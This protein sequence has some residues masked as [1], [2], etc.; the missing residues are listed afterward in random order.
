MKVKKLMDILGL[1][2]KYRDMLM[3]YVNQMATQVDSNV[4]KVLLDR[5]EKMAE[6]S[7]PKIL[8]G[9]QEVYENTFTDKEIEQ[10]IEWYESDVGKKV[11]ERYLDVLRGCEDAAKKGYEY[12]LEQMGISQGQVSTYMPQK[13]YKDLN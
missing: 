8:E 13:S 6:L 11:N 1:E 3:K 9:I 2:D 12:A 5:G 4:A 7:V 10:M